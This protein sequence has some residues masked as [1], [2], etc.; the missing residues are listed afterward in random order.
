MPKLND[1]AGILFDVDMTLT[2][3]RREVSPKISDLL[4]ACRERGLKLGTCTGRAFVALKKTI[5]PLFPDGSM[6][7]TSGGSQVITQDGQVNWQAVLP[8]KTC[9]ELHKLGEQYSQMYYLP[10]L[11]YGY[12]S[13]KFIEK[14]EGLHNLVPP[15]RPITE[16]QQWDATFMVFVNITAEFQKILEQRDDVTFRLS[17]S[18][19]NF[20]SIDVTPKGV[21]KSTGLL[22]WCKHYSLDPSRVIGVGDSD[23]DLEFLDIVG[24]AVGMGNS[25]KDVLKRVDRVIDHTN[26]NGLAVYLERI[27]KGSDL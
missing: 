4:Q 7:I 3:S 23:N 5:L 26:Q 11:E 8:E 20:T 10:T 22:Q 16:L 2:N 6:H 14:Y 12:G 21:N 25:T 27:L 19:Q 18:T 15:L 24:F 17:V 9:Y 13:P 1:F